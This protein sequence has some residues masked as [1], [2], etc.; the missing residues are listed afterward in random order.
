MTLNSIHWTDSA[1][2]H[3]LGQIQATPNCLRI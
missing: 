1:F 3:G 2:L